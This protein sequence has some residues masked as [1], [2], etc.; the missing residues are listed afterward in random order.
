[1][2]CMYGDTSIANE[3]LGHFQGQSSGTQEVLA[4]ARASPSPTGAV[5]ARDV[6]LQLLKSR[7]LRSNDV[8]A[9]ELVKAEETFRKTV[10]DFFGGLA[11]AVCES[12]NC[13]ASSLLEGVDVK[14]T[15]ENC[16]PSSVVDLT[17]HKEL[18]DTISA[19]SCSRMS[20]GDYSGKYAKLLAD[21]C[22]TGKTTDQL[23]QH[24]RASCEAE[25]LT[26]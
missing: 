8:A 23:V 2:P 25:T 24:V 1:M 7:A 12:R 18:I 6:K 16:H 21:F 3:P 9:W 22:G 10:D 14:V 19:P 20:W 13:D 15:Y 11:E 17:C 4:S 26:V 5:D